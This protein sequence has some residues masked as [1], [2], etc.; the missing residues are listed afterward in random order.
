MQNNSSRFVMN[1]VPLTNVVSNTSGL[2]TNTTLSNSITAMQQMINTDTKTVYTN[3][4]GA[5][6]ANTS[7]QVQSPLNLCNVGITSNGVATTFGTAGAVA[8]AQGSVSSIVYDGNYVSTNISGITI[9]VQGR[10][11]FNMLSN[12][13]SIFYDG[14][15]AASEV[16][17]SS[18]NFAADLVTASSINVGGSCF[19]N[20]FVTLSDI[21]AKQHISSI[22]GFSAD[23][24]QGIRPYKFRYTGFPEEEIG[25]MAQELEAIYPECISVNNGTKYVK[26]NSVLALLL[27]TVRDL[28]E[29]LTC[30]ERRCT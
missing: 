18:M 7:I 8:S 22:D 11:I 25:L 2:D 23:Q 3:F 27:G 1:L 14:S 13:N 5:F 12:G 4:L 28:Q 29:R 15:R 10:T 24:L 26:Y 21:Q 6:T 16:R 9:G 17:V 30:L 20:A 19:A